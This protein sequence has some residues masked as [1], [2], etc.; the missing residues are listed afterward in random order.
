M[1]SIKIFNNT[2]NTIAYQVT[3]S[4]QKVGELT[5]ETYN[6]GSLFQNVFEATSSAPI[7]LAPSNL[8]TRISVWLFSPPYIGQK[9]DLVFLFSSNGQILR[10]IVNNQSSFQYN[11]NTLQINLIAS[12]GISLWVW[13]LLGLIL[14]VIII[15]LI[16]FAFNYNKR[17]V[18]CNNNCV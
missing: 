6:S 4:Y 15:V 8:N 17:G 7:I 2:R 3:T 10:S 9:S 11:N 13:L 5:Q 12:G 18:N 1:T 14:L 16:A